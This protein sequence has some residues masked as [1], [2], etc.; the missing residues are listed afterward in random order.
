MKAQ[1]GDAT[2]ASDATHTKPITPKSAKQKLTTEK[3]AINVSILTMQERIRNQDL[4][5]SKL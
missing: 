5:V 3:S 4:L 2:Q 1:A